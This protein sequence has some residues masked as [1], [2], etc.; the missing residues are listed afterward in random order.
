[1]RRSF[2]ELVQLALTIELVL[3]AAGEVIPGAEHVLPLGNSHLKQVAAAIIIAIAAH[4]LIKFLGGARRKTAASGSHED[5][6]RQ[7]DHLQASPSLTADE[8]TA[9][10]GTSDAKKLERDGRLEDIA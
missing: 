3:V 2:E 6:S 9:G 5:S 10:G 1:M 7:V 8:I 4:T